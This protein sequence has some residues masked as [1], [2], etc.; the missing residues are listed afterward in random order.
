MLTLPLL[1]LRNFTYDVSLALAHNS[2]AHLTQCFYTGSN[3]H[4][5]SYERHPR[6][7]GDPVISNSAVKEQWKYCCPGFPV[8]AGNDNSIC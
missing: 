2:L 5:S 1:M 6:E 3:F 8:G 7:G 4:V